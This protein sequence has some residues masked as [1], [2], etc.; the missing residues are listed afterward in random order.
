MGTVLWVTAE[1]LRAVGI[2]VQP[3]VPTAA[4]KLLNLLGISPDER[5]LSRVGPT[6]RLMPG[7]ALPPP[8]PIFPRYVEP[9][10]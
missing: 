5:G 2:L 7:R 6:H 8:E 10:T 9:E 3:F 4:G 1:T